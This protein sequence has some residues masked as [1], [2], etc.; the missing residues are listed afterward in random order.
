MAQVIS[1]K[2][3]YVTTFTGDVQ[4]RLPFEDAHFDRVIAI[5]VL[6]HLPD[7]PSALDEIRRVLR[8]GGALA[9]VI[10]CEGGLGYSLGR[11]LTTQRMF[12]RRYGTDYDWYIK[13][14]HVSVPSEI[15]AELDR[16]F[17][18]EHRSFFPLL[19]PSVDLNLC[20]GLTYRRP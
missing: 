17:E 10:P 9:I 5:H 4:Q 18:R 2:H 7:L 1:E 13:T 3:P 14:E 8:P 12:E 19:V 15:V 20:L 11:R 16:R 6:E